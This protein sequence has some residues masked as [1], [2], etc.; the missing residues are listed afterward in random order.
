MNYHADERTGLER[1]READVSHS[2]TLETLDDSETT[3]A[4]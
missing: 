1:R 3:I 2:T 4:S